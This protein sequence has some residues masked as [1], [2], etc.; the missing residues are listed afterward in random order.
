MSKGKKEREIYKLEI[1]FN[2]NLLCCCSYY[3]CNDDIMS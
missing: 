3:I 1:D 2:K